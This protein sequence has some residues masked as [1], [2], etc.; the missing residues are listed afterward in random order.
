M[1]LYY[2][3]NRASK[4]TQG[5]WW[6]RDHPLRQQEGSEL[7]EIHESVTCL[8]LLCGGFFL[9]PFFVWSGCGSSPKMAPG[10]PAKS[11]DLHLTSSYTRK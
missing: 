11:Y 6:G 1:K 8:W 4:I 10:T 9:P 5:T 7:G 2:V 3:Q